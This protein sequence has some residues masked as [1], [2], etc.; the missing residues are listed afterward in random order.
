MIQNQWEDCDLTRIALGETLGQLKIELRNNY[1]GETLALL[2]CSGLLAIRINSA[3]AFDWGELPV[4][5]GKVQLHKLEADD[6]T[7]CLQSHGYGFSRS[8]TAT[9]FTPDAILKIRIEGGE[10]DCEVLA[11][12]CQVM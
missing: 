12:E 8:G 11:R 7:A 10:I 2:V 9:P 4:F 3:L 5:V 6:A 1:D